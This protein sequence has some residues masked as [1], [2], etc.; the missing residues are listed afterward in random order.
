MRWLLSYSARGGFIWWHF[1]KVMRK[2]FWDLRN[3]NLFWSSIW[4]MRQ[5]N[6][7]IHLCGYPSS[8]ACLLTPQT[9]RWQR[10]NRC[11]SFF[12]L[13]HVFIR[14]L[15]LYPSPELTKTL[16]R[17][18][19]YCP[20]RQDESMSLPPVCL[21][22]TRLPSSFLC[23]SAMAWSRVFQPQHCWRPGL[24]HSLWWRLSCMCRVDN[25]IPG[26]YPQNAH[27]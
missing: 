3:R 6:A 5:K 25:S 18:V 7:N 9:C 22:G 17:C 13:D 14:S 24:N 15:Q 26:L 11:T 27:G 16:C 12:S 20:R 23:F 8:R 21:E 10:L 2:Y 4:K 1:W 19:L